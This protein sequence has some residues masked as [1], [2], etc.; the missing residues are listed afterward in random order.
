MV[1]RHWKR[2]NGWGR[3]RRRRRQDCL[4]TTVPL[5]GQSPA[6]PFNL[7]CLNDTQMISRRT[8]HFF[9]SIF[10]LTLPIPLSMF[11]ASSNYPHS[12][13]IFRNFLQ[14]ILTRSLKIFNSIHLDRHYTI[15][16]SVIKSPALLPLHNPPSPRHANR[17]FFIRKE[18]WEWPAFCSVNGMYKP[19]YKTQWEF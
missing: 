15:Q 11:S 5:F 10:F 13:L 18:F 16:N 19:G 8:C 3:R 12:I 14:F 6:F 2:L 9:N 17:N 4:N 7:H 1:Q